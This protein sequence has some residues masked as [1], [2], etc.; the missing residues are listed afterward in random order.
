[1][2]D[3]A[4]DRPLPFG[5]GVPRSFSVAARP[6]NV[7]ISLAC[8]SANNGVGLTL[9]DR[10]HDVDS[11]PVSLGKIDSL[12]LHPRF[13]QRGNEGLRF[14]QAGPASAMISVAP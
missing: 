4:C 11:E 2:T 13:Y 7:L 12:E 1:L 14:W 5:V 8:S 10:G 9:G 3:V 6:F